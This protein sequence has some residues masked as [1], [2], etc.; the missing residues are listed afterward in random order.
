MKLSLR[1]RSA[2]WWIT[3]VCCFACVVFVLVGAKRASVNLKWLQLSAS[4]RDGSFYSTFGDGRAK[5]SF[6]GVEVESLEAGS[7]YVPKY[8]DGDRGM[9][10][11]LACLACL[12]AVPV[13]PLSAT[14]PVP[15]RRGKMWAPPPERPS[16]HDLQ[17]NLFFLLLK[18]L[19]GYLCISNLLRPD[20]FSRS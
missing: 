9:L 18:S 3:Q 7:H 4:G 11:T 15:I 5:M 16:G 17:C 20:L 12:A 10:G 14:P 1:R 19:V 8:P 6:G 2:M 13:R